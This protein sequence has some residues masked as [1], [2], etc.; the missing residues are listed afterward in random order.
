MS[1]LFRILGRVAGKAVASHAVDRTI[2]VVSDYVL[3]E[4]K[5]VDLRAL[6]TMYKRKRTTHLR[7]LGRCVY[8][9]VN[10]DIKVSTQARID[11][12]V[13]VIGE[14]E[15]EISR[16]EAE[17]SHRKAEARKRREARARKSSN[18]VDTSP[19]EPRK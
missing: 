9:L 11:E 16:V 4:A 18:T 6:R 3:T 1:N 17:I 5:L 15:G 14:I 13:T 10:N 7:T 8:R 12:L 19:E 2:S